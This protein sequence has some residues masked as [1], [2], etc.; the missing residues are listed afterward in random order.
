MDAS[1]AEKLTLNWMQ[2]MASC[3]YFL[4]CFSVASWNVYDIKWVFFLGE[5]SVYEDDH[6]DDIRE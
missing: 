6:D 1:K 5:N 3:A 2:Y 4:I